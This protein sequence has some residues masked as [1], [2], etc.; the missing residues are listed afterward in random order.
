MLRPLGYSDSCSG[1]RPLAH[2]VEETT[3]IH[4]SR[5]LIFPT[6]YITDYIEVP[7]GDHAM[8]LKKANWL[9]KKI[10]ELLNNN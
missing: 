6:V 8:I 7:Q 2:S 10:P 9:N 4:G 1:K 5:D 3:H